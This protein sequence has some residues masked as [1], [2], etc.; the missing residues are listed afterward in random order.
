M[1]K[2]EMKKYLGII[3][4]FLLLTLI[5]NLPVVLKPSSHIPGFFSTDEPY[6]A[7]WDFWRM[8]YNHNN[9]LSLRFT[10]LISYPFGIDLFSSGF[11][12]YLWFGLMYFLAILTNPALTYNIQVLM[13]FFLSALFMYLLVFFLTR[14]RLAGL[15]SGIVFSFSPQHFVRSWQHLGISYF[16]WIPLVLLGTF[17]L[18][19][20]IT[21]T[22]F[23][24]FILSIF[25]LFSF[26]WSIM[27]FGMVSLVVFLIYI[28]FY[29][30]KVKLFKN[31]F[32]IKEN[33]KYSRNI[34]IA[35]IIALLIL[36]PQFMPIIQNYFNPPEMPPSA[37]NPY[38][39][40]FED[41]FNQSAKP[42]SY[43]LPST[44][45]PIFGRFTEHFV[46]SPLWGES[47][48]EHQ[49]YLGWTTI[50]LALY[51][52][53][54]WKRKRKLRVKSE[55]LKAKGGK[56]KLPATSHELRARK[57]N[58][59]IGFFILLAIVA[60]LFSQPPWW[61]LGKIK[62]LLPSYFMYKILPMF[63][64]YCRF[65]IVVLLAMAVLAGVGLKFI[66]AERKTQNA[67]R[68]ITA[69]CCGLILFEFWNNPFTH[70]ID[71]SK[72]PPV[73]D[74]LKQ[75]PENTI[76]AEYPMI[77]NGVNEKYKFYQTIHHKKLI[78]GA[79]P[80]MP[81]YQ[82]KLMILDLGADKTPFILKYLG[83]KYIIVHTRKYEESENYL[84][85]QQLKKIRTHSDLKLIK[86]FSDGIEVYKIAD[87][88]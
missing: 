16:E 38:H 26:D 68:F 18:K 46:G 10:N 19:D 21:K 24:L 36:F 22:R 35:G 52:V 63:R 57:D 61:Q 88:Q 17:L 56:I 82:V 34:V 48:T 30:W 45:H 41:L 12:S 49:L 1:N 64:A 23:I 65:G 5:L 59:Y 70:Y 37:C 47:Y 8:Q 2:R 83:A 13:N 79:V 71:L 58:F 51:A 40:P 25:L 87:D 44:E 28:F 67:R 72:Y 80:G 42:L 6:A 77:K 11:V 60:W 32:L 75:L 84:I 20:K 62:I 15:F 14:S 9:H 76:I 29:N 27:Y 31:Y 43:L 53:R 4:A 78:N 50:F 85:C 69:L 74:W 33:L 7:V 81:G 3:I 39:R 73:Y 54:Q 66:I 55:K 86:T